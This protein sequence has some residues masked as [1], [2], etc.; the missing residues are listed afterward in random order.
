VSTG[1]PVN[2]WFISVEFGMVIIPADCGHDAV[3]AP[4]GPVMVQFPGGALAMGAPRLLVGTPE[5]ARVSLCAT[6][7]LTI[8][9]FKAS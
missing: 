4:V 9:T 7:L 2:V 3:L 6:V 1:G 8:C 5:V